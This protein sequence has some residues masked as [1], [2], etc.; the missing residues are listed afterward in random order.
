VAQ[1]YGKI[2]A[3]ASKKSQYYT[4]EKICFIVLMEVRY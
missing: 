2:K 3:G 1:L 4:V